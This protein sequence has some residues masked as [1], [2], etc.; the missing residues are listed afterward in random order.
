MKAHPKGS[1]DLIESGIAQ[2]NELLAASAVVDGFEA[3][4]FREGELPLQGGSE[5]GN[6]V[7]R[8]GWELGSLARV[9]FDH[10]RIPA[11]KFQLP[12]SRLLA[13]LLIAQR[14]LGG[15]QNSFGKDSHDPG[16]SKSD[17]DE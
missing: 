15:E 10:A 4:V 5:L 13:K 12:E 17:Y 3:E 14:V 11:D 7:A 1:F 16:L 9:D 6:M 8:C 2:L